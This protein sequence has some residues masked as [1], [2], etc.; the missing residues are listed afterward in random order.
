MPNATIVVGGAALIRYYLTDFNVNM[1]WDY[2]PLQQGIDIINFFRD[3]N[4]KY[5]VFMLDW[6]L[7]NNKNVAYVTFRELEPCFVF[8]YNA[9]EWVWIYRISLK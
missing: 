4:V 1:I 6:T 5:L 7:T 9:V 8:K 2:G 3:H